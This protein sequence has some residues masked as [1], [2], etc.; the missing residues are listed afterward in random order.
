M[1]VGMVNLSPILTDHLVQCTEVT[2]KKAEGLKRLN[3]LYKV[4]VAVSD[5][6]QDLKLG[7]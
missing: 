5:L 6:G 1:Y 3:Y 2:A 7:F 4:L